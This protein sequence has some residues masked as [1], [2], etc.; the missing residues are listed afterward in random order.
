LVA[1]FLFEG[2]NRLGSIMIVDEVE[3]FSRALSQGEIQGLYDAGEYGKCKDPLSTI[4][5]SVSPTSMESTLHVYPNPAKETLHLLIP[6]SARKTKLFVV[7]TNSAGKVVQTAEGYSQDI[8]QFD[9]KM[10]DAGY[11]FI[12]VS[13]ENE[14]ALNA[15]FVVE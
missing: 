6:P 2:S 1:C 13:S 5:P 9:L 11:Y 3:V 12:T 14:R 4:E 8:A 10:M 7:I 15:A